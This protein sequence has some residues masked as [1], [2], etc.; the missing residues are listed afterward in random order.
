MVEGGTEWLN[1]F[2]R[3]ECG[4]WAGG[5]YLTVSKE[6]YFQIKITQIGAQIF[7]QCYFCVLKGELRFI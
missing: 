2:P 6:M 5:I 3:Q 7:Q 4:I 1:T